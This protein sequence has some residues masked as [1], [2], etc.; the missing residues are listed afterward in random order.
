MLDGI[1]EDMDAF[2]ERLYQR[3][4]ELAKEQETFKLANDSERSK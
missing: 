4:D 3:M 2:F 1:I